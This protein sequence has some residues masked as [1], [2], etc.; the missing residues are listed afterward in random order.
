MDSARPRSLSIYRVRRHYV[1]D[2]AWIHD[3]SDVSDFTKPYVS[4]GSCLDPR[5]IPPCTVH[6]TI[7]CHRD[8]AWIHDG[9]KMV[10][11]LGYGR[12]HMFSSGSCLDPRWIRPCYVNE[13]ICF[14]RG[15]AWIHDGP[16]MVS[17]LGGDGGGVPGSVESLRGTDQRRLRRRGPLP[18]AAVEG[19]GPRPPQGRPPREVTRFRAK[20]PQLRCLEQKTQSKLTFAPV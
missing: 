19:G 2:P 11:M 20:P 16:R 12:N 13:T 7:F 14:Q 5:W 3:G 6:E 4:Y 10:S 17:M 1:M 9:S 8:P 15:P 18:G